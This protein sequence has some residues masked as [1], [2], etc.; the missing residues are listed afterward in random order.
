MIVEY[1]PGRLVLPPD[2]FLALVSRVDPRRQVRLEDDAIDALERAGVLDGD[3]VAD[4]IRPL[5]EAVTASVCD[6]MI[7]IDDRRIVGWVSPELAVVLLPTRER[8]G[9]AD[10]VAAPT[11]NL[12]IFLTELTDLG[13]RSDDGRGVTIE[14]DADLL[15]AL[16]AGDPDEVAAGTLLGQPIDA[17]AAHALS[18]LLRGAVRRWRVVAAWGDGADDQQAVEALDGATGAWLVEREGD[19]ARLSTVTPTELYRGFTALLPTAEELA[20]AFRAA[21]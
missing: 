12:P 2:V 6:L 1:S 13:P 16:L 14:L 17:D 15:P 21:R 8:D 20:T 7:D 9:R 4:D 11:V 18:S 10:V 5:L 3:A 19:R